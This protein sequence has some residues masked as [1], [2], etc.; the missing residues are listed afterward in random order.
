MHVCMLNARN[1]LHVFN[2]AGQNWCGQTTSRAL[3]TLERIAFARMLSSVAVP[4]NVWVSMALS[5]ISWE[6]WILI[7]AR[8]HQFVWLLDLWFW[9]WTFLNYVIHPCVAR[10]PL[11]LCTSMLSITW[12]LSSWRMEKNPFCQNTTT[13]CMSLNPC[14]RQVIS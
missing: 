3:E 14:A 1:I 6:L 8:M 11:T 13:C 10:S 7:E 12:K 2:S 5:G 9:R 4:A